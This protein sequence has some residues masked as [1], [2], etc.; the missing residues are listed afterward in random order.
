MLSSYIA[1]LLPMIATIIAILWDYGHKPKKLVFILCSVTIFGTIAAIFDR[2][3]SDKESVHQQKQIV[4]LSS[5]YDSLHETTLKNV[6]GKGYSTFT[7]RSGFEP[8][9]YVGLIVNDNDYPSYNV[10]IQVTHIES[11]K[12]CYVEKFND[13]VYLDA[14]CFA[15]ANRGF[16]IGEV[17]PK[18]SRYIN[19]LRINSDRQF[20]YLEIT[21][22][23]RSANVLQQVIIKLGKGLCQSSYRIWE[24]EPSM[25]WNEAGVDKLIE[26]HNGID[27]L[28]PNW[29]NEFPVPVPNRILRTY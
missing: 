5:K 16:F 10:E 23:S 7:V 24:F 6:M 9:E 17:R 21:Y 19:D 4:E 28:N 13:K 15:D 14:I 1:L 18:S 2:C 20:L 22:N 3:S 26:T 27:G 25:H 11:L 29:E 8:G 12:N